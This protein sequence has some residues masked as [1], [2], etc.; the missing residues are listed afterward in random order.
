MREVTTASGELDPAADRP[1]LAAKLAPDRDEVLALVQF[2]GPPK[3][4]WVDRLR[5]TGARVVGYQAQNAYVAHAAGPAVERVAGLLGTDPAVR[6]VVPL[7]A[8]D[9]VEGR[10][11]G[12]ARYVVSS[13]P[14]VARA[15]RGRAAVGDDRRR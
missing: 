11:E 15:D 6:A 8:A 4:A 12:A 13:V 10:A 2:V 3:P 14:G 5:A 1:S 7:E 9:K